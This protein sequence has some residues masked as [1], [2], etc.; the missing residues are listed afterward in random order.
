[1]PETASGLGRTHVITC[2]TVF[3][4]LQP[5]LPPDAS[6]EVLDFG[7]H[8]RPP[9]LRDTLQTRLDAA[10]ADTVLLGYGLCSLAVVGLKPGAAQLVIPRVDDCI[11]LFLGSRTRYEEQLSREPG[12]YYLTK[13]WIEVADT[14]FKEYDRLVAR[15]GKETADDVI[16]MMFQHYTRLCFINTGH[17]DL[18]RYH[19]YGREMAERFKLRFET[20]DGSPALVQKLAEGPWDDEFVVVP[21]GETL[22]YAAFNQPNWR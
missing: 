7:L 9:N 12:T 3:E 13:G 5:F 22:A 10:Q 11:A 20:V 4:E 21:P 18:T 6:Y 15:Y 17:G 19:D 8:Q 16:H 1:M 14:P 2:A